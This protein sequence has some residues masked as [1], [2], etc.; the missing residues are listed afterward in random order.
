MFTVDELVSIVIPTYNRSALLRQ[1]IESVMAQTHTAWEVLVIDDGSTEPIQQVVE[2]F[3]DMRMRYL[4]Q[5]QQGVSVARNY[6][7]QESKGK[8]ISF[9][10]SDDMYEPHC[11]EAKIVYAA[12]HPDAIVI[13]A[14][15]RYINTDNQ[16]ILHRTPPRTNATYDD[17]AIFTAFPGGTNN[18]FVR[19]D[20]LGATG[21]FTTHLVEAEDRELLQRL[22]RRGRIGFVHD[23][24]VCVRVHTE[25]RKGRDLESVRPS[26]AWIRAQ[27][28]DKQLRVR[29]EAWEYVSF[30]RRYWARKSYVTGVYNFACSFTKY[31]PQ[32]HPELSRLRT[33]AEGVIPER[34]YSHLSRIFR[35]FRRARIG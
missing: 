26:Y 23:T 33:I 18:I 2:S 27:M 6:G 21:G 1:A 22:S 20:A 15:C 13:G 31:V 11:L 28:S 25:V 30:G 5:P 10:D 12:T 14:G 34:L 17:L 35:S 29:S 24:L 9:L 16:E 8:F 32:I 3:Q 19:S 7:I 4:R